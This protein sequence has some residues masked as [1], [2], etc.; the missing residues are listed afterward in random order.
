MESNE[1][2]REKIVVSLILLCIILFFTL[3]CICSKKY[4]TVCVEPTTVIV[5]TEN[6]YRT[7]YVKLS[8]GQ[9]VGLYTPTIKPGDAFCAKYQTI[10]IDP[11][12]YRVLGK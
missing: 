3:L 5:I 6:S 10:E 8:N 4:E 2:R 9:I 1:Y 7:T 11:K 12:P